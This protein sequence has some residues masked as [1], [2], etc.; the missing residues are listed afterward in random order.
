M[1]TMMR[2][3]LTDFHNITFNGFEIKLPEDTLSIISEIA[4]QVGSPTYIRT[5]TF[6]KK[7]NVA[8]SSIKYGSIGFTGPDSG[9]KRRKRNKNV[10]SVNDEDWETI[11]SFQATKI[12]QKT[13]IDSK[14]DLLRTCLNKLTDKN[15][16]EL[17][18]KIVDNF[19]ELVKNDT[20][21]EDML[22]VGNSIF[23][24]ASNNRFFSK[25]YADLYALLIKKFEVMKVIFENSLDTFLELFKTIEYVES[26]QDYD[27]FCKINKDNE[28]RK[29]LSLFF[30]NLCSNK[31]ISEE[32]IVVIACDLM[33]QV[34]NLIKE[35]NKKNE[36]DE[37][38]ENIAILYNKTIFENCSP[39]VDQKIENELYI[40][41]IHRLSLCKVKTYP[42]LSNKSIFKYMDMIDM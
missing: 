42:S 17:I 20:S 27:R 28:K 40:D 18:E 35:N 4:Q 11:R 29:A 15:Y 5:P 41:I 3:N 36:V 21:D 34:V 31:I 24:I 37:I 7:E 12:E 26:E 38:T 9:F 1:Q 30:V 25:M 2:Y 16:D 33:K 39:D 32:K 22:K 13:G 8:S 23:D 19:E 14:I 10:E 6:A